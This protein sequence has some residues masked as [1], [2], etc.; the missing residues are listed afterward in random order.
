[1]AAITE[2]ELRAE[3]ARNPHLRNY[4]GESKCLSCGSP[5]TELMVTSDEE[6]GCGPCSDLFQDVQLARL[7][8]ALAAADALADAVAL[9]SPPGTLVQQ[10]PLSEAL[11]AYRETRGEVKKST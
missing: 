10:G 3:H 8:A 4:W 7:N 6:G 9:H 11:R 2:T 1:M 5:F